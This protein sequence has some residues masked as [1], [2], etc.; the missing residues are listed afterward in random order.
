MGTTKVSLILPSF[1]RAHL[2][3]CTL[4][5]VQ[6]QQIDFDLDIVVVNDGL[7]DDTESVCKKYTTLNIKYVFSGQRNKPNELKSRVAGFALNIGVRQCEGDII[8]LSC[9]EVYHLNDC[10]MRQTRQLINNKKIIVTPRFMYFDDSGLYSNFIMLSLHTSKA[11][12]TDVGWNTAKNIYAIKMPYFMG[13]W[14]EDYMAIGGYDEDLT[15]YAFDDNDFVD[16]ITANGCEYYYTDAQ[17]VHLYHGATCDSM[18]QPQNKAWL[19]N[20]SI[21]LKKKGTIVRNQNRE[22]GKL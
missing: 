6:K 8:L 1:L 7:E 10:L 3:D 21:Y 13:M 9:A 2:L 14:K 12:P 11:T 16:R 20:Q 17:I 15:G 5:S 18:P 22:W 4:W 19:H